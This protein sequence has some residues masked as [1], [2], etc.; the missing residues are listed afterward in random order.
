M[1]KSYG[2]YLEDKGYS[3]CKRFRNDDVYVLE[4]HAKSLDLEQDKNGE[5]TVT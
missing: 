2:V 3:F 4:S 5:S 1:S